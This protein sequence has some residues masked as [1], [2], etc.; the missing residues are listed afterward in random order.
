MMIDAHASDCRDRSLRLLLTVNSDRTGSHT[1]Q[2]SG[3]KQ[4]GSCCQIVA[5]A[6]D[7]VAE[8]APVATG[9]AAGIATAVVAVERCRSHCLARDSD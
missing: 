3:R 5:A 7:P 1:R 8:A 9:P 6:A 4:S 2:D